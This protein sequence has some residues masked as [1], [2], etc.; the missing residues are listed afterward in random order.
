MAEDTSR[1]GGDGGG[2]MEEDVEIAPGVT[3]EDIYPFVYDKTYPFVFCSVCES[4]IIVPS[5]STH[6]RTMHKEL[7]PA[8]QRNKATYTVGLLPNMIQKE[9]ELDDYQGPVSVRKAI[10]YL[11]EPRTDGLKCAV[12]SHMCR[13]ARN[14]QQH[15]RREHGLVSERGVG[16]PS[17]AARKLR[18]R[19]PW[20][21]GVKCQRLFKKRK[22]SRWF[23]V[24]D[25]GAI[26]G[27]DHGSETGRDG[28]G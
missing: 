8:Q 3:R 17:R 5:A 2:D 18:F 10:P 26:L 9:Q 4:G 27:V 23:E 16:A 7:V 28:A 1:P 13:N 22:H 24:C 15:C 6:L 19:V 25:D 11:G 21:E 12:C 14:M 20:R